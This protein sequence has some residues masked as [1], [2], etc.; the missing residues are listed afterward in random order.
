MNCLSFFFLIFI[1]FL[2]N[3]HVFL[4]KSFVRGWLGSGLTLRC[5]ALVLK[6]CRNFAAMF[7]QILCFLHYTSLIICCCI[8]SSSH[9]STISISSRSRPNFGSFGHSPSPALSAIVN[10]LSLT[11]IE[12]TS[13]GCFNH[14]QNKSVSIMI[15]AMHRLMQILLIAKHVSFMIRLIMFRPSGPVWTQHKGAKL[16]NVVVVLW[17]TC[18]R[19]MPL[20][21]MTMKIEMHGYPSGP[22]ISMHSFQFS[23]LI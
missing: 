3:K 19:T 4:P 6:R 17:A 2:K 18:L 8:S 20:G 22:S 12:T 21:I 5:S 1:Q 11:M 9:L 13:R 7:S 14:D 23:M 16:R 10:L 15:R